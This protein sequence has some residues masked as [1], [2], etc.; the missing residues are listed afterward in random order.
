VTFNIFDVNMLKITLGDE[1]VVWNHVHVFWLC[2]RFWFVVSLK[3]T[4]L[5]CSNE[6]TTI[7]T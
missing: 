7:S 6:E 3:L 2:Q 1:F 4:T 5:S